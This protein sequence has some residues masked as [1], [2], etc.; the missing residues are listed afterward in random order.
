M[1]RRDFLAASASLLASRALARPPAGD[2]GAPARDPYRHTNTKA[3]L[4]AWDGS[5]S[6]DSTASQYRMFRGN[7]A[8]AHSG[9]GTL[10]T[11][12]KLL[13]KFKMADFYTQTSYGKK[14]HWQGMGW[15]GQTL[16]AGKYV[17]AGSTGGHM[18][19]LEADTGK[20]VWYFTAGR[21]FKG[22]P[23]FYKNRVICPNVDNHLRCLDGETGRV[24]W[25]W[26]SPNDIDSSP[27]VHENKVYVGGE[28]G[29]VKCLDSETGKLVW[30]QGFGVGQGEKLG[31]GGIESSLAIMDDIAYFGHLDGKVRAISTRDGK[32]QWAT[33]IGGD[34]DSSPLLWKDRLY[35]GCEDSVK[36]FHC[37]DRG[38]GKLV[39]DLKISGGVWGSA[40]LY[41]DKLYIGG[42]NGVMYCL[43]P[44][45]GRSLWEFKVGRPIWASPNIV[46][47]K[48]CFG[49]YDRHYRMLDAKT[50][51]LLWQHDLGERSH[52]GAAIVEGKIWVGNAGGY[53]FCFG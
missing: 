36:T 50:G 38:T 46:D 21:S 2:M 11:N 47:G 20:L 24:V 16:K 33:K 13:W 42:Q 45:T 37:L 9:S 12:L 7:R 23:C 31:S 29:A 3:V 41:D 10:G 51:K 44:K 6:S 17:Y 15:T 53:L 19:C 27:L 48:V 40:G 25:S 52:S 14:Y 30:R 39:W 35:I 34:T 22:S 32:L 8:H 4:P 5:T 1:N 26:V 43:D 18:H 28:D 49:S